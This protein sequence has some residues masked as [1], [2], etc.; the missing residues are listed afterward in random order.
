MVVVSRQGADSQARRKEA[1]DYQQVRY[2]SPQL[3]IHRLHHEPPPPPPPPSFLSFCTSCDFAPGT[4]GLCLKQSWGSCRLFSAKFSKFI[5]ACDR[6]LRHTPWFVPLVFGK[7]GL[8]F[9]EAN[10]PPQHFLFTNASRNI[11]KVFFA[12]NVL[13]RTGI[14]LRP[15]LCN[16][17]WQELVD[18]AR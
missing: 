2:K 4:K 17:K 10:A 3:N 12:I 14:N 9:D 5:S 11:S 1:H 6:T 13:M 18:E 8:G 7:N 16:C 15:N